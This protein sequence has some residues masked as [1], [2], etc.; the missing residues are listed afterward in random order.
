MVA[1]KKDRRQSIEHYDKNKAVIKKISFI[2]ITGVVLAF[3][4]KFFQEEERWLKRKTQT[5]IHIAS[6]TGSKADIALLG[7]VSKI[8]KYIHFDVRVQAEYEGG[9]YKAK[10]LNEFQSLLF[11]YF[12]EQT[13]GVLDYQNLN[14]KMGA[15]KKQALVTFDAFFKRSGKDIFCKTL[16]EWIKEKKWYIKKIEIF[17]CSSKT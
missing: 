12:K 15:N 13:T 9:V 3:A 2:V 11:A 5:I 8:A 4:W 17:S 7:R 14:V 16:W 10:S 1:E 6:S